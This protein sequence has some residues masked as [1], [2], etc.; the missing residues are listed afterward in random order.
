MKGTV[1]GRSRLSSGVMLLFLMPI[2]C[3]AAVD[4][5][6]QETSPSAELPTDEPTPSRVPYQRL[7]PSFRSDDL[8]T[9]MWML[10]DQGGNRGPSWQNERVDSFSPFFVVNLGTSDLRDVERLLSLVDLR[11]VEVR[12]PAQVVGYGHPSS[13]GHGEIEG[14][15]SIRSLTLDERIHSSLDDLGEMKKMVEGIVVHDDVLSLFSEVHN[16]HSL[17]EKM[18]YE[19]V[20]FVHLVEHLE[21]SNAN[22]STSIHIDQVQSLNPAGL[23]G[24]GQTVSIADGGID[25]DHPGIVN[26]IAILSSNFGPDSSSLDRWTGHG[27]HV[28]GTIVGDSAIEPDAAGLAPDATLVF[29]Q[30]EHDQTGTLSPTWNP[31]D[32]LIY[33]AHSYGSRL[34]LNPWASTDMPGS[35]LSDAR[36][37]DSGT[38]QKRDMLLIASAGNDL[39]SPSSTSLAKNALTVG[40]AGA[41]VP[42]S[43][44]PDDGSIKP[45]VVAPG[46]DVCSARSEDLQGV[47][48]A[49]GTSTHSDGSSA[50][51][52]MTGSSMSS[53]ATAASAALLRQYLVDVQQISQPSGAL[54]KAALIHGAEPTGS[55]TVP[56]PAEGWGMIN[57]EQSLSPTDSDGALDIWF[58]D[59]RTLAPGSSSVYSFSLADARDLEVTLVWTDG[60]GSVTANASVPRLVNDLDLIVT[61]PGSTYLGNHFS[62]GQ[63]VTGGTGDVT[64]VVER[65]M[66]GDAASGEWTI[67][68]ANRAGS[69]SDYAIVISGAGTDLNKAD[70][71]ITSDDIAAYPAAPRVEQVT[72]LQ[73][74]WR[75]IGTASSGSYEVLVEDLTT[76]TEI[77]RQTFP[78]LAAGSL[79]SLSTETRFTTVGQHLLR[80]TLDTT[81]LVAEPLDASGSEFSDNTIDLSIEVSSEGVRFEV[82]DDSGMVI[83]DPV[84]E[85]ARLNINYHPTSGGQFDIPLQVVNEGTES[86]QFLLEIDEVLKIR[87]N[88]VMDRAMG[89]WRA[90][91]VEG[92]TQFNLGPT[93]LSN[94]TTAFTLRIEDTTVDL[95][96][97]P[98]SYM[99][100]G[101]YRVD[102]RVLSETMPSVI[103]VRT[104][105]FTILRYDDVAAYQNRPNIEADPGEAGEF[106]LSLRN[107][108]NAKVDLRVNC[109]SDRGWVVDLTTDA[110]VTSSIDLPSLAVSIPHIVLGTVTVPD[111]V[112]G[113]PASGETSTISCQVVH[114]G[115]ST[116]EADLNYTLTVGSLTRYSTMLRIGDVDY[117]PGAWS[118]DPIPITSGGM[119]EAMISVMNRGNQPV[120]IELNGTI[121]Q[122]TWSLDGGSQ[123]TSDVVTV[124]PSSNTLVNLSIMA[125][126][127]ALEA[128]QAVLVIKVVGP[129]EK[130]EGGVDILVQQTQTF[131][132]EFIV[133]T[134]KSL[135]LTFSEESLTCA[136]ATSGTVKALLQN[137]GNLPLNDIQLNLDQDYID[138]GW[139]R[140]FDLIERPPSTLSPFSSKEVTMYLRPPSGLTPKSL[141]IPFTFSG[142]YSGEELSTTTNL[143]V[144]VAEG[145][146]FDVELE[147]DERLRVSPVDGVVVNLSITNV[148]NFPGTPSIGYDDVEGVTIEVLS[149]PL[150]IPPTESALISMRFTP[151]AEL[152][153]TSILIWVSGP[154]IEDV[155]LTNQSA[156]LKI[157][158]GSA[159]YIEKSSES[160]LATPRNAAIL[161]VVVVSILV[162]V[163]MSM[164]SDDDEGEQIIET[165]LQMSGSED[166]RRSMTDTGESLTMSSGGVVSQAEI[167][168]A[169]HSAKSLP[170]PPPA[171]DSGGAF[172]P[173]GLPPTGLPP[174]LPPG[175]SGLPGGLPP[176]PPPD[177]V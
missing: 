25:S 31:I 35:Y 151:L 43:S 27:T 123:F 90:Q 126:S 163:I 39:S 2:L 154:E 167:Q 141:I 17:L 81:G 159:P 54:M 131:N 24:A 140:S 94:N 68:V 50:H 127:T 8:R 146:V 13:L 49:C 63:S 59:G 143:P 56:N 139:V 149:S 119:I 99:S 91:T 20:L 36:S 7:T 58:D 82:L 97:D 145:A 65:I 152:Q 160:A 111:V 124:P 172:P 42:F 88:G 175:P 55:A 53:A 9:P 18:L 51:S 168:A 125:S 15:Q 157:T 84:A 73:A 40:L 74:S 69:D 102:L 37:L 66:I 116:I 78:P 33:D 22:T 136:P 106:S 95:N 101:R 12:G 177:K 85:S 93:T 77:K 75:N 52:L 104:I 107:E 21:P 16:R 113:Y 147:S 169:L 155:Q 41:S 86:E 71:M 128:D 1:L 64:N 117:S 144:D 92:Y 96:A 166:R 89:G 76:A 174:G 67:R 109:A 48:Q 45:D 79:A 162:F 121:D 60:A 70:L 3:A 170:P 133:S 148:G 105:H 164:R 26:S 80:V 62:N 47:Y 61:G 29:F 10:Q 176:P 103:D 83:S 130:E 14:I 171:G 108:G 165:S 23:S 100:E 57:L 19:D 112:E 122:R 46:T 87:D 72:V 98:P 135:S 115:N 32:M 134:L 38:A 150:S 4:E 110:S 138:Q 137:D 156:E 6:E 44:Y 158:G 132:P 120:Q 161:A 173:A 30:I 118:A 129:Y 34:H 28:G 5:A 153:A 114:Q 142:R 11:L